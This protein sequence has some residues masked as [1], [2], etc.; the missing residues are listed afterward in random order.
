MRLGGSSRNGSSSAFAAGTGAGVG[1]LRGGGSAL[2]GSPLRSGAAA[3]SHSAD[4]P[5]PGYEDED[6]GY[7]DE[8]IA[9]TQPLSTEDVY[10]SLGP[11]WNWSNVDKE[12]GDS[13]SDNV[14]F[15]DDDARDRMQ[16]DFGDESW[17]GNSTP[18]TMEVDTVL[19][20]LVEDDNL[21]EIHV[22]GSKKHN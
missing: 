21:A 11:S 20:L 15:D 9:G 12:R 13:D 14:A 6:E 1:V 18:A 22:E 17:P 4:S 5:P 8:D 10:T 16:E 3:G 19:P 7:G 2:A